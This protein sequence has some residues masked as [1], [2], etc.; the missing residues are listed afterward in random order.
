MKR[1]LAL[2]T[3]AALLL[4]CG[5]AHLEYAL[6]QQGLEGLKRPW[7]R[8]RVM[9]GVEVMKV[10]AKGT[11]VVRSWDRNNERSAYFSAS[12]VT[13]KAAQ[14]GLT[15][16]DQN[17]N[18]LE[19]HLKKVTVAAAKKTWLYLNDH[20]FRGIFEFHPVAHDTFYTVNILNMEDYLRGVLQPEIGNR[21]NDEFEAVK[22]QAVAARTYA[23]VTRNKYPDRE[24]DLINDIVDQ[25]YIGVAGEQ[26]I[27]NRAVKQTRGE[28]L[29]YGDSLIDAYYHSTCAGHTDNIEDVWEKG[30]R[31]Y[32]I[33]VDDDEFCKWSKYYEW[34]EQFSVS[35]F[36]G[37]V[38]TYLRTTNGEAHKIGETLADA[39]LG[40][41]TPGNRLKSITIT[42]N[43]GSVVLLRD[44]IRWAI[45]RHD[46]PGILP[47]TNFQI[48]LDRDSNN[49]LQT[50]RIT[51]N[52]YGHGVGMCQCGAIGR[53]RA[54]AD[55]RQILTHYYTG[56]SIQKLY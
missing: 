25:V 41:R 37:H 43:K 33:G 10:S 1:T 22:A 36:L 39:T 56:V 35:E 32:L 30:A 52:G 11:F 14:G 49:V 29:T 20:M 19:Q 13:V 55:Y 46:K 2:T 42:T 23:F 6:R 44:Q 21:T 12:P 3:I 17:G 18:V 53:A 7:M 45:G 31:P 38:R 50:V 16:L 4:V 24:Y 8:V 47:S 26:N 15:L 9:Q 54:G 34:V 48:F 40:D 27:T 5:C 28:V 51:G